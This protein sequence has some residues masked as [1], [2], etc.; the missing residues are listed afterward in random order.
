MN[1]KS[2]LIHIA[3]FVALAGCHKTQAAS[4]HKSQTGAN[5]TSTIDLAT[6]EQIISQQRYVNV[7]MDNVDAM[8]ARVFAALGTD[9]KVYPTENYY[10]F[11][12]FANSA[13]IWGNFRLDSKLRD[14]GTVSFAYFMVNPNRNDPYYGEAKA[15]HKHFTAA[16]GVQIRKTSALDYAVTYNG[17]TVNFALN[18]LKQELPADFKL[19]DGESLAGRLCDESGFQFF[20]IYNKLSKTLYYVLDE[21]IPLVDRLRP[22]G[23]GIVVG[24]LSEFGFYDDPD[25]GRKTLFAVAQRN[26]ERNSYYDGPFDQLPDNFVDESKFQSIL[27]SAFPTLVGKVKGR[28]DFVDPKTGS[29]TGTRISIA[30]YIAYKGLR[31]IWSH[32]AKCQETSSGAFVECL[33]QP[34]L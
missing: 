2:P 18:D 3:L 9:V 32:Y 13:E 23:K 20:L 30:S 22:F 29:P 1:I 14:A 27:E 24:Q 17:K 7:D 8:F 31:D 11:K 28:G 4:D 34:T 33:T 15:W 12:F 25:L 10:Y 26:I 6:N 5:P 21:S 16:D 19:K